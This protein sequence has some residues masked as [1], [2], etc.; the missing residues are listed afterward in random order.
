MKVMVDP[1]RLTETVG[2]VMIKNN[3]RTPQNRAKASEGTPGVQA[4][5]FSMEL[6]QSLDPQTSNNVDS[7]SL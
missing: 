5:V 1:E 6:K 2:C 3:V 7:T 4:D